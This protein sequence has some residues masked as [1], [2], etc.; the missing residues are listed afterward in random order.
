MTLAVA[1]VS[2]SYLPNEPVVKNVGLRVEAGE[3][4]SVLGPSGSGKTTLLQTI[5]GLH[6]ADAGSIM[7]NEVDVTRV[8]PEKR[9]IALVPQDGALFPHLN[10]AANIG[11]GLTGRGYGAL[12]DKPAR[13]DRVA[14]L[15]ELIDMPGFGSRMP[16]QLSGGQQQRVALARALAPRP[17]AVLLDEPF[18]SL[19]ANLRADVRAQVVALLRE[20]N[21]PA[22]LIT[23]DQEEAMSVSDT[24]AI[25]HDGAIAQLGTPREVYLRPANEFVAQATGGCAILDGSSL[26]LEPGQVMIRPEQFVIEP[27]DDGAGD[28]ARET[29]PTGTRGVVRQVTFRGRDQLVDVALATGAI[30]TVDAAPDQVWQLED[31]VRI[32][33][34]GQAHRLQ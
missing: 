32:S 2:A 20:A 7:L 28:V 17:D 12:A 21:V 19:D 30:V 4:L 29:G 13:A 8:P 14:E 15:L 16:Q 26:G 3:I 18:S 27:L 24:V 31:N 1:G 5:S 34:P 23:H 10:V 33:L 25:L 11:Y 22:L 9:R 6:P